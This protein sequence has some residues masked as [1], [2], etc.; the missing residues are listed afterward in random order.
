[1]KR[2]LSGNPLTPTMGLSILPS[3]FHKLSWLQIS[4]EDL[5]SDQANNYNLIRLGILNA[6]LLNNV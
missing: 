1:M 6:F 3:G 5:V 2:I 4:Y